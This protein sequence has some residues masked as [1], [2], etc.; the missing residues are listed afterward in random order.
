MA[1]W[2]LAPPNQ[3][4][5]CFGEGEELGAK[6]AQDAFHRVALPAKSTRVRCWRTSARECTHTGIR[7]ATQIHVS[8]SM[9]STFS[10]PCSLRHP[11]SSRCPKAWPAAAGNDSTEGHETIHHDRVGAKKADGAQ[12]QCQGYRGAEA[13]AQIAQQKHYGGRTID[14]EQTDCGAAP[15]V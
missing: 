5:A 1:S 13:S 15:R 12:F 6:L 11:S 7:S 9:A 8:A 3:E 4:E 14:S 10:F 2:K